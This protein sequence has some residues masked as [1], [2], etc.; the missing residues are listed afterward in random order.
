MLTKSKKPN[1]SNQ[2]QTADGTK[3]YSLVKLLQPYV[4]IGKY[5]GD[6]KEGI[7]FELL[8]HEEERVVI[9]KLEELCQ[10]DL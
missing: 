1:S 6:E 7:R 9:P 4:L 3:S 2:I 5:A 10:E 8:T